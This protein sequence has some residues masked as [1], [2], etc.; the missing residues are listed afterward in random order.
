MLDV[1]GA[2]AVSPADAPFAPGAA[3]RDASSE[4]M[5]A[6]QPPSASDV[7]ASGASEASEARRN[8]S[9]GSRTPSMR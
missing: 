4:T 6:V 7:T 2:D 5:G 3:A 1:T 9:E 8:V